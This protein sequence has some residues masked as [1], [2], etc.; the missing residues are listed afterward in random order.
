MY[1][2]IFGYSGFTRRLR[3]GAREALIQAIATLP[4]REQFVIELR[5]GLKDGRFHS[6]GEIAKVCPG[7][8]GG[9][10]L[11]AERIRQMEAMALRRLRHPS[12]SKRLKG[13]LIVEEMPK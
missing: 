11:T 1:S 4:E 12:R 3:E 10:G 13:F 2:A 9:I 5:F 8:S 6:L 7:H